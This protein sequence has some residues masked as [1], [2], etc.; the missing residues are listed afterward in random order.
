[1]TSSGKTGLVTILIE[2][3]LS[4][5]IPA[6]VID[7]KFALRRETQSARPSEFEILN[8]EQVH[9]FTTIPA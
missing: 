9:G 8:S 5:G 3:A 1:M 6:I 4:A 7:V 2:E